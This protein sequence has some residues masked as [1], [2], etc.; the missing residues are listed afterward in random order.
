MDRVAEFRELQKHPWYKKLLNKLTLT[1]KGECIH[2]IL[3]KNDLNHND[4]HSAV[5]RWN[6]DAPKKFKNE[7]TMNELLLVA[8]NLAHTTK[9]D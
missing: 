5:L 7:T 6:L 9:K 3:A 8:N 1:E 2:F 4:F